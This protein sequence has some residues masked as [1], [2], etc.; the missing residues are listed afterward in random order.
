MAT[1]NDKKSDSFITKL[2][3]FFFQK[4]FKERIKDYIKKNDVE[5]IMKEFAMFQ[6]NLDIANT[7]SSRYYQLEREKD[8]KIT[9]N[10]VTMTVDEIDSRLMDGEKYILSKTNLKKILNGQ[11]DELYDLMFQ[12]Y[13]FD[14]IMTKG[15]FTKLIDEKSCFYCGISV[16]QLN[17]LGGNGKLHNKRSETRGFTLEIDRKH[18]NLEY[19]NENCCMSCY[20]CNNAK[21]DEFDENEFKEIAKGIKSV[22]NQRLEP[23][24]EK[25]KENPNE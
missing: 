23:F 3:I 13:D 16:D 14:A 24:G 6:L 8:E 15:D 19:T 12:C 11:G 17:I 20:W 10:D 7:Y 5:R 2:Q 21:T 4:A 9:V 18:P 22:W 1:Y 25:I